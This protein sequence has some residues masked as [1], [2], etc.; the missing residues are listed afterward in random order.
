MKSKIADTARLQHT[1]E[2]A[3]EIILS[4]QET[5]F[6]EFA[7]DTMFAYGAVKPLEIVGEA[8]NHISQEFKLNHP[9][10]EWR[11]LIGLRNILVHE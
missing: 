4:T 5:T 6:E 8:T 10:I 11:E 2:A 3:N 7:D 1:L 9:E